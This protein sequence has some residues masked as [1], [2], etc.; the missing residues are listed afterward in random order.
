MT[1]R[2]GGRT[3]GWMD[4]RLPYIALSDLLEWM[5]GWM[6]VDRYIDGWME[7]VG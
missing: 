2:M 7:R 4:E 6:H 1:G 3:D 5:G